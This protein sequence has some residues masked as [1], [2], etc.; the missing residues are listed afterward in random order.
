MQAVFTRLGQ[1]DPDVA[2]ILV[3]AGLVYG[4]FGWRIV[5]YL[6][7]TDALVIAIILALAIFETDTRL[8]YLLPAF[9]VATVLL[10]GL[11]WLAWRFSRWAVAIMCGVAGFL[12]VQIV[13]MQYETPL[14]IRLAL[15]FLGAGMVMAMKMTLT[16][17]T[18]IIVTGLH[19]GWLFMAAL[20]IMAVQTD[21]LPGRLFNSLYYTHALLVPI[22]AT[23]LSGIL[24]AVQW[25]DMERDM[26]PLYNG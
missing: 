17:E 3:F 11:P 18:A 8:S 4:L 5:R 12:I 20:A 26:N 22:V 14:A 19:G 2:V 10:I 16:R 13:L 15:G 6:A 21:S 23:C 25:A 1:L 24:I 7:F 9:P